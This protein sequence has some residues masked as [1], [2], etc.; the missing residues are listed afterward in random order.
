MLATD[1]TTVNQLYI[2]PLFL[3]YLRCLPCLYGKRLIGCTVN[4]ET[5]EAWSLSFYYV[6]CHYSTVIALCRSSEYCTEIV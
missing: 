4:S 1:V 3:G 5:R 6:N 2:S